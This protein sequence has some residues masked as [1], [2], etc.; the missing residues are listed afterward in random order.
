MLQAAADTLIRTR[1]RMANM[2]KDLTPEQWFA[3]PEGFAN[4]IAWNVGHL[5][6]AQQGLC[7]RRTNVPAPLGAEAMQAMQPLYGGGTSPADWS[8]NPDTEELLRLIVEL[9]M[10]LTADIAAG[11]FDNYVKPEPI[12]GRFPP[13][14]TVLHALIFNI[15]HEG[16][17][18]GAIGDLVG[19]MKSA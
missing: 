6:L 11:K 4:N 18:A 7:Y 2:L 8:E 9:P 12:E 14:E 19:Y 5:V 13:P 1:K 17:H 10:Q 3:Q 15:Y 16:M